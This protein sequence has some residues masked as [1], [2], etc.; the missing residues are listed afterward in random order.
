MLQMNGFVAAFND[1]DDGVAAVDPKGV[2][3]QRSGLAPDGPV[4]PNGVTP[5]AAIARN[6]NDHVPPDGCLACANPRSLSFVAFNAAFP[7]PVFLPLQSWTR[8]G[9]KTGATR[10]GNIETP[11]E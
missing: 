8:S 9:A 11:D 10:S 5:S 2:I 6:P 3:G 4:H 7:P 1:E